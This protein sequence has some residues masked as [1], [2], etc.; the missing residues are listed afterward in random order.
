MHKQKNKIEIKKYTQKNTATKIRQTKNKIR[1]KKTK[2]R[3]NRKRNKKR[4]RKPDRR[5]NHR[6]AHY[7]QKN[8]GSNN[9]TILELKN[10]ILKHDSDSEYYHEKKRNDELDPI[11]VSTPTKISSEI[12]LNNGQKSKLNVHAQIFTPNCSFIEN[13][14]NTYTQYENHNACT[15]AENHNKTSDNHSNIINNVEILT[16]EQ[17]TEKFNDTTNNIFSILDNSENQNNSTKIK[18][19]EEQLLLEIKQTKEFEEYYKLTHA[20]KLKRINIL[21]NELKSLSTYQKKMVNQTN[22]N[23]INKKSTNPSMVQKSSAITKNM[24]QAQSQNSR[25]F[26]ERVNALTA[27]GNKLTL[28]QIKSLIGDNPLIKKEVI[29]N[30]IATKVKTADDSPHNSTELSI[31]DSISATNRSFLS[32]EQQLKKLELEDQLLAT[33]IRIAKKKA[34]LDDLNNSRKE[35]RKINESHNDSNTSVN[36]S[37]TQRKQAKLSTSS[38][39]ENTKCGNNSTRDIENRRNEENMDTYDKDNTNNTVNELGNSENTSKINQP[40]Q[41]STHIPT[42]L[43]LSNATPNLG[44]ALNQTNYPQNIPQIPSTNTMEP[45]I[46]TL[47]PAPQPPAPPAPVIPINPTA[48]ADNTNKDD[49]DQNSNKAELESDPRPIDDTKPFNITIKLNKPPKIKCNVELWEEIIRCK[50]NL[51]RE[52]TAKYVSKKTISITGTSE[53]TANYIK[54][55]WDQ[56]AF[57][58]QEGIKL[59]EDHVKEKY[60]IK[61]TTRHN[62]TTKE[63]DKICTDLSIK[64]IEQIGPNDYKLICSDKDTHAKL[65]TSNEIYLYGIR[66]KLKDW[67]HR[68]YLDQCHTCQQWGHLKTKCTK[69]PI[70]RYCSKQHESK[71]CRFK[72][73]EELYRCINCKGKHKS[74]DKECAIYIE[75]INRI[76]LI[77]NKPLIESPILSTTNK[78]IGKQVKFNDT[79][80]IGENQAE[81]T[82]ASTYASKLSNVNNNKQ[83]HRLAQTVLICDEILKGNHDTASELTRD[84]MNTSIGNEITILKSSTSQA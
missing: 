7:D 44:S 11:K 31:N 38:E 14:N 66:I 81:Q 79:T 48:L 9:T 12:S 17:Y 51:T 36:E 73:N 5:S 3:R 50:P 53:K 29:D 22:N 59:I 71:T 1:I 20:K 2:Y 30:A 75:S 28:A 55:N 4:R 10:A 70:C 77:L 58:E 54:E 76:N 35:K 33:Q 56:N 72:D 40:N 74:D 8:N 47:P 62:L 84:L 27:G 24:N 49:K 41:N 46:I 16:S 13:I 63:I 37:T 6:C 52:V 43:S 19:I 23:K 78:P 18:H 83:K 64:S 65:L 60:W 42:S 45:P 26:T 57:K 61:G 82:K 21:A 67:I 69:K 80:N 34:E 32:T 25:R 68:T 39:L 15:Q